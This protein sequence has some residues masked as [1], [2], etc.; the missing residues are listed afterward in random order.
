MLPGQKSGGNVEFCEKNTVRNI[1]EKVL[2]SIDLYR[3]RKDHDYVG[4]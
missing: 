4:V 2:W 3:Y 1:E